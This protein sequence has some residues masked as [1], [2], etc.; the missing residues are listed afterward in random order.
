MIAKK[1]ADT[2]HKTTVTGLFGLFGLGLYNIS[3]QVSEGKNGGNASSAEQTQAG[4]LS[5]IQKKAEEEYK[6]YYDIKHRE[7]YD[8][9]DSSYLKQIPRPDDY[10]PRK[11]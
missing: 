2:V 9:D 4:F 1:I 11:N 6:K 8:K 3:R 5:M 7:W 10:T